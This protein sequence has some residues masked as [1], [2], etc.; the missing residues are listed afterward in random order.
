MK[1][2][3]SLVWVFLASACSGLFFYTRSLPT[4]HLYLKEDIDSSL[5]RT[6]ISFPRLS[7]SLII[8]TTILLL[9]WFVYALIYAKL[10]TKNFKDILYLDAYTYLPLCLLGLALTH[11]S[12]ICLSYFKEFCFLVH[13]AGPLLA[14]I[15]LL[16]VVYLKI[17]VHHDV[18]PSSRTSTLFSLLSTPPTWRLKFAL[19]L[20]AF[21]LYALIGN[22]LI[23]HLNLGGDEPHYLMITHSLIHDHDLAVGWDPHYTQQRLPI[24][25]APSEL[26]HRGEAAI[27]QK[28]LTIR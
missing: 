9:L 22:R 28:S 25:S 17:Q 11:Y 16:A 5:I 13:S 24:I 18:S 12:S 20:S 26:S 21:I 14:G 6:F 10:F 7:G 23:T 27:V 2:L 3:K 4:S 1:C 8:T 19:F 15:A